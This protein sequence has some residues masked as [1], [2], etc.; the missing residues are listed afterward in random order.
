LG[1][2]LRTLLIVLGR[3]AFAGGWYGERRLVQG[4]FSAALVLAGL[5]LLWFMRAR[6]RRFVSGNPWAFTGLVVLLIFVLNHW[7]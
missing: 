6:C 2:N 1:R 7:E 5:V 3:A 4:V